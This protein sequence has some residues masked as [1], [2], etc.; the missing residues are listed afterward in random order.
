MMFSLGPD[1]KGTDLLAAQRSRAPAHQGAA[2]ELAELA[3]PE[4]E[5]LFYTG[6]T[7][8]QPKLVHHRRE[9]F[10]VLHAIAAFYLAMGEPPM[11]FLSGS[12]FTHV[13][14]QIRALLTL[15]EGGT[16]FLTERFGPA[17]FLAT[18]EKERIS[19]SFLTPALLY[20]V[21]D[22]PAMS[23]ADTSSM[24]YLNVGGAAASPTRLAEAITKFCPVLRLVYGLSEVPL[25]TDL[26][27]LDHG[28]DH[29]HR[30]TSCGKPSANI[31]IE[32]RDR[33]GN[34]LPGSPDDEVCIARSLHIPDSPRP[35]P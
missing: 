13:S 11:R 15:F 27:F 22:H 10:E 1:D 32:I 12:G 2:A 30:P 24:R 19:S 33:N 17:E 5:S 23:A 9:F 26:P 8:G 34:S 3:G 29:P 18:I 25:I 35:P 6:G 28:P 16:L 4:P 31:R 14:G 20:K 7:T 21:L